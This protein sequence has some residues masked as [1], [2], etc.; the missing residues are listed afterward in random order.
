[1]TLAIETKEKVCFSL[2]RACMFHV[3]NH[4]YDEFN[5][6]KCQHKKR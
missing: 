5:D 6:A 1:M 3:Q 4:Q 2:L